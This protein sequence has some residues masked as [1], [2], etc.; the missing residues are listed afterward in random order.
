MLS[1]TA[2]PADRTITRTDWARDDRFDS[3]ETSAP[4]SSPVTSAVTP[5]GSPAAAG[6]SR[7]AVA[8]ALLDT[9]VMTID[10]LIVHVA[11]P[12]V[13]RGL[14]GVS[15]LQWAVDGDTLL[16]AALLLSAGSVADKVGA[17]RAF[18]AGL[19]VFIAVSA[20]C[21]LRP[22]LAVLVSA[23]LIQGAGATVIVPA[24]LALTG[25]RSAGPGRSRSGRWPVRRGRPPVRWRAGCSAR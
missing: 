22:G 2:R 1:C 6:S 23:R 10:A 18:G 20:L 3:Q 7:A 19:A 12:A 9:F 14:G 5:D 25:T 17:R 15:G 4:T 16:F 13:G 11:L 8:A 24:S 21:G